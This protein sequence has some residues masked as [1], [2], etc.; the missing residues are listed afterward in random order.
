MPFVRNMDLNP[1][2][3]KLWTAVQVPEYLKIKVFD[4]SI[5]RTLRGKQK[6]LCYSEAT[7]SVL[8]ILFRQ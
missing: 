8:L 3:V 1:D 7:L 6:F 5:T 4:K 2:G